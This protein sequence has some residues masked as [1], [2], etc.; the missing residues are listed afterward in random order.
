MS[1]LTEPYVLGVTLARQVPTRRLRRIER[2]MRREAR[3]RARRQEMD[4]RRT[5]AWVA[6]RNVLRE[7][8]VSLP[9]ASRWW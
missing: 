3:R 1:G 9:E 8:G 7:R 6:T 5:A 2:A 4:G